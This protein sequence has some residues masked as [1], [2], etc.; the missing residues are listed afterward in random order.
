[1]EKPDFLLS[2]SSDKF[3]FNDVLDY[4]GCYIEEAVQMINRWIE[5][6][7]CRPDGRK[8][9]I[10]PYGSCPRLKYRVVKEGSSKKKPRAEYD[11][12]PIMGLEDK[13]RKYYSGHPE[14]FYEN[15]EDIILLSEWLKN[16]SK[17]KVT[18]KERAYEIWGREKTLERSSKTEHTGYD[19]MKACGLTYSDFNCYVTTEPFYTENFDSGDTGLILENRDPWISIGKAI[20]E[21][22]NNDFFGYRI[23]YLV[24]GEGNRITRSRNENTGVG[25]FQDYADIAGIEDISWIYAGDIDRKGFHIADDLIRSNPELYI[26]LCTPLYSAMINRFNSSGKTAEFSSDSISEMYKGSLLNSFKEDIRKQ[27]LCCLEE[28]RRIPQEILNYGDY[29]KIL[30]R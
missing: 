26:K 22:G 11:M 29:L 6:G 1:M 14:K 25:S 21:S 8:K 30:E 5:E 16:P 12:I 17:I 2:L 24:F 27:I 15:Q 4:Y 28:N 9:E 20:R 3:I 23:K 13:L 7:W 10:Y 18:V 19:I